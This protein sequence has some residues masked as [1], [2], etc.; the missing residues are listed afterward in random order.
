[1]TAAASVLVITLFTFGF[2]WSLYQVFHT[3]NDLKQ[4]L[5]T[6]GVYGSVVAGIL[7]EQSNG[8]QDGAQ[9]QGDVPVSR[10]EVQQIIQR[11]FPPEF[12]QSQTEGVIDGFYNW[13]Q[14]KTPKLEFSISLT[15]AK[16]KLADGLQQYALDRLNSLPTC[17]PGDIPSGDIDAYNA[18]CVPAGVDKTAIAAKVHDQI[19]ADFLKDSTI[20]PITVKDGNGKSLNQ[21]A[22]NAPDIYHKANDG[23]YASGVLAAMLAAAVV[24]L[25]ATWRVGVRKISVIAITVGALSTVLGWLS[26]FSLHQAA[27]R[28]ADVQ[29]S[30]TF[31]QPQLIRIVET[32]ADDLRNWWMIYGLSL[33]VLGVAGLIALHLTAPKN[34]ID[35][36]KPGMPPTKRPKGE[37]P[38]LVEDEAGA[39]QTTKRHEHMVAAPSHEDEDD[40]DKQA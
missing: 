31:V 17:T 8:K 37:A 11:S 32:L 25:A 29:T 30:N 14:G 38:S 9:N 16:A 3:P 23:V 21:Q 15:Q 6:S 10:P 33:I 18:T 28:I 22:S 20:T 26:S 5:R 19:T 2:A 40:E 35:L 34:A 12:L 7:K 13:L 27:H 24:S 36:G 4:A 39:A 1:M